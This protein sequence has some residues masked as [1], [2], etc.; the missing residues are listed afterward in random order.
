M[1]FLRIVTLHV[2][3]IFNSVIL[4]ANAINTDIFL[5]S[6]AEQDHSASTTDLTGAM[7]FDYDYN[8]ALKVLSTN[9]DIILQDFPVSNN[10]TASISLKKLRPITDAKTM[11]YIG[12]RRALPPEQPKIIRYSG[13]VVGEPGSKVFLT[14]SD[15]R[16]FCKVSHNDGRSFAIAPSDKKPSQCRLID[17]RTFY[18]DLPFD[19]TCFTDDIES[20]LAEKLKSKSLHTQS[21]KIL[22]VEIAL[23]TDTEFFKACGSDTDKAQ[24]YALNLFAMV[25]TIYEEQLG[26]TIY[27]PALITWT[28]SPADPYQCAG[29]PFTLVDKARVYWEENRK[30]I[31]RDIF[32]VMTSISY[33]GGG[34]GYFDALGRKDGYDFSTSSVQCQHNYPTFAFTYDVYIIAHEM[35]HNFNGQHTHSCYWGYPLDTCV[36][37]AAIEGGCLDS[38]SQPKPNPGSIMSYCGGTNS[39]F[40][41]GYMVEMVFL[42]ENIDLMRGTAEDADC[43]NEPVKPTV[44]LTG[45]NSHRLYDPGQEIQI[46]WKSSRVDFV[47]LHIRDNN[48]SW[49]TIDRDID[50]SLG[51][52]QFKLPEKP[53]NNY[54]IKI[55]SS[56]DDIV[57][58]ISTIGFAVGKESQSGLL[59]SYMFAGNTESSIP[60]V[61]PDAVTVSAVSFGVDR[62]GRPENA[63]Q[64]D[65]NGFLYIPMADCRRQEFSVSLWLKADKLSNKGFLIGTDYGPGLNVF[66]I[67][68]WGI[69]GWSLYRAEGLKQ[70]WGPGIGTGEWYHAVF[71]YDGSSSEI[72][73]NGES[74]A[75]EDI[76]GSLLEFETAVYI[77]ARNGNEAFMGLIDDIKIFDR[78]VN[79]AKVTELF[80]ELPDE[81]K[82]ADLLLPVN[83][84]TEIGRP[85][86]FSWSSVA[87][88]GEYE[89][90]IDESLEFLDPFSER[91]SSEDYTYNECL[92]ETEYFWRV[93]AFIN[94]TENEFSEVFSFTT[95][96]DVGVE[97]SIEQ[98]IWRISP[99]PV[100]DE[101]KISLNG[102]SNPK[103]IQIVNIS[104]IIL[105]NEMIT[106]GSIEARISV[107][108]LPPGLY[109][110]KLMFENNIKAIKF[111]KK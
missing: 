46:N 9:G 61:Y 7:T 65:G 43:L 109:L 42:D 111:I 47:D 54:K 91:L 53:G 48:S 84:G 87:G 40:G 51:E 5:K 50:A 73:L 49:V 92:P 80:N 106:P 66:S 13:T 77:G 85:V 101:L 89:I 60:G 105:C 52:Y 97:G 67:Y 95:S 39:S 32:H 68:N 108:D 37:A 31:K 81:N 33:G 107:A 1:K 70:A 78:A 30:D 63:A 59:G 17:E 98:D 74:V 99:N 86:H 3:I 102:I 16:L 38:G 29:N 36:T 103:S 28:D 14:I 83:K 11:F 21:E 23:E 96:S 45:P 6:S 8:N 58:D 20:G 22:E 10:E 110:L 75:K 62:F 88:A 35:G 34:F 15:K 18:K 41:M 26:I 104:G 44:L 71:V 27:I 25:T 93:R 12:S 100:A 69:L 24:W 64:F 90:E 79:A 76:D 2:F 56:S 94:D 19:F 72:Y 82:V 57:S 55:S 4:N